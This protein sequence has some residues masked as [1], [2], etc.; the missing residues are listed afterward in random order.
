MRD[1][2]YFE[3]PTYGI[4]DRQADAAAFVCPQCGGELFPGDETYRVD[5][6]AV[7]Q[8]CFGDWVRELFD[9]SP[10]VLADCLRVER[11]GL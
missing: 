7:C 2:S 4:R 11:Q 5:G 9:I 8:G 10:G 1:R 6:E 3:G